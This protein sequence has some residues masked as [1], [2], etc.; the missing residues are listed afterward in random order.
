MPERHKLL[1]R[2]RS[3]LVGASIINGVEI[4]IDD[5]RGVTVGEKRNSLLGQASGE[6]IA[7][8]DDDDIVSPNYV[9]LILEGIGK[10]VDCCSLTGEITFDGINP[11][12]FIH[13]IEYNHYFEEDSIY[14][15]PPNHLNT[16]KA[17]IAKQFKF[18]MRSHGEDTDW[19]LQIASSGLLK[20]EHSIEEI[21]YY[22]D[23]RSKK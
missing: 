2:L 15:R 6:Y 13:S 3:S 21:L 19:S 11:K 12:K 5:R 20:T 9:N 17:S 1:D 10:E 22:Y 7:F 23:Y 18:P 4:L 14:Y 16:I 8:C